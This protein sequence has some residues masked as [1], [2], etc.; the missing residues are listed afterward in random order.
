MVLTDREIQA[1][2]AN[3]QIRITPSPSELAFSSTSL[4]LTLA[5]FI[6]VWKE[7]AV[8]GVEQVVCPATPGYIFTNFI[9]EFTDFRE[10]GADGHV[11][12]PGVFM[13]GWTLENVELPSRA[14]L[15]ARVEGKSSL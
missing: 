9:K 3:D 4:D 2:L 15:A 6:R 7:P 8:V 14:R 5:K 11:L 12:N 13:L 1:A 10:M